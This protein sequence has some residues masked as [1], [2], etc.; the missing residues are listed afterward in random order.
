MMPD[1]I[2][3]FIRGSTLHFRTEAT[4]PMESKQD[5]ACQC[6]TLP[7]LTVVEIQGIRAVDVLL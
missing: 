2:F 7:S 4:R 1:R 3:A 5:L 6:D